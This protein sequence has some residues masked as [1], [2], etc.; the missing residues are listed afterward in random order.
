M[1]ADEA[2]KIA[3]RKLPSRVMADKLIVCI[4]EAIVNAVNLQKLQTIFSY[5][6]HYKKYG[7]DPEH[8]K[9]PTDVRDLITAHWREQGYKV[10]FS[11]G[12]QEFLLRWGS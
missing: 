1:H 12:E 7:G 3:Q 11:E 8:E 5:N 9:L 2:R 4:D 6:A 10:D